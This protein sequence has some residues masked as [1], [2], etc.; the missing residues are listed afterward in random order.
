MQQPDKSN[1][2]REVRLREIQRTR[3]GGADRIVR[4]MGDDEP[5]L[6]YAHIFRNAHVTTFH[7]TDDPQQAHH[8]YDEM[9]ELVGVID[10]DTGD[11]VTSRSQHGEPT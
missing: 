11:V 6:R 3:L 10:L 2:Q 5:A 7:T 4:D 8:A 9:W 1:A